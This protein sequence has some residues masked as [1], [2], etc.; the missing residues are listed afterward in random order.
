[1]S[2]AKLITE[3]RSTWRD[4]GVNDVVDSVVGAVNGRNYFF[5]REKNLVWKRLNLEAANLQ[6]AE[7]KAIKTASSID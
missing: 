6:E 4:G 5:G 3:R 1:M 2:G 7:L